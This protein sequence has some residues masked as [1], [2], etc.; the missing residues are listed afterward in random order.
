[1]ETPQKCEFWFA[2][3]LRECWEPEKR[4]EETVP[5]LTMSK[6][7]RADAKLTGKF[8]SWEEKKSLW[9]SILSLFYRNQ[10]R[11]QFQAVAVDLYVNLLGQIGAPI[12]Q[13]SSDSIHDSSPKSCEGAGMVP[14]TREH[15]VGVW[16][17]SGYRSIYYGITAISFLQ[18]KSV[19]LSKYSI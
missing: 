11:G 19:N 12:A 13:P 7:Q 1:M 15:P 3:L 14:E 2:R 6:R 17:R 18:T 9:V 10:C 8:N 16:R 5:G 4:K